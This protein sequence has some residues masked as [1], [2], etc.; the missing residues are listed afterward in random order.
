[1][2][3]EKFM[4]GEIHIDHKVP[5]SHFKYETPEDPQFKECWALHNLQPM[6]AKDNIQKGNRN[7]QL[8]LILK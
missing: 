6:W 8:P 4:A 2:T 5:E 1:M 7:Y 3:W